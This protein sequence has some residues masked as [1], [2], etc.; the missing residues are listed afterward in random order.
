MHPKENRELTVRE[1]LRLMS[2]SDTYVIPPYRPLSRQ[3]MV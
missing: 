3:Y 2:V 1:C